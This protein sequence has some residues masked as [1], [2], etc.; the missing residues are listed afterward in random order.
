LTEVK[1]TWFPRAI[2]VG[3]TL[4]FIRQ[5]LIAPRRGCLMRQLDHA[6]PGYLPT[7]VSLSRGITLPKSRYFEK[8]AVR[9]E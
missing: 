2:H 6:A 4:G 7:G 8:Q 3:K 5:Q 9:R 1:L